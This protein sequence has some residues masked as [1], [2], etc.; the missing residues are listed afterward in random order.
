MLCIHLIN[1]RSASALL[2]SLFYDMLLLLLYRGCTKTYHN[3]CLS[4]TFCF[5]CLFH[6]FRHQKCIKITLFRNVVWLKFF[7]FTT[8]K[9]GITFIV[10]LQIF[11]RFF[12]V[13]AER[14]TCSHYTQIIPNEDWFFLGLYVN[15]K[16][17]SVR[18]GRYSDYSYTIIVCNTWKCRYQ[19]YFQLCKAW[20]I[21]ELCIRFMGYSN[22]ICVILF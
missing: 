9:I 8:R 19:G 16:A 15:K 18:V 13:S 17:T 1:P 7:S 2:S 14:I 12:F 6:I 22:I 20:I 3:S 11:N 21:S 4:V 10:L 5:F